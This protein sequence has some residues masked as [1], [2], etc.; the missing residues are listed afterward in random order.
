[1]KAQT[2]PQACL[3]CRVDGE[4]DRGRYLIPGWDVHAFARAVEPPTMIG[5]ANL[6]VDE[7]TH[8]EIGT[9]MRAPRALHNRL[10]PDPCHH[11]VRDRQ[12]R[13]Q[14]ARA[15]MRRPVGRLPLQ[16]PI[17][18]PRLQG[19]RQFPRATPGMAT[20]KPRQPFLPKP[21]APA[22]DKCIVAVQLV[23]DLRS[24]MA[25]FQQQ[26]QP[27]S[28]SIVGSA[29]P[30]RRPLAQFHTFR[31][32]QFDRAPR[33]HD[34]TTFYPLQTT[35]GRVDQFAQNRGCIRGMRD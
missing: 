16:R 20:E 24:A 14:L 15:P 35:R 26:Y 4:S 32:R 31:F 5:A 21:L 1:L 17:Q 28:P 7:L 13:T 12:R 11:H 8:G 29:A 19:R 10:C 30:A 6:A 3:G 25:R 22:V 2:S 18:D 33:E 9:E 27:R 23:A 34:Y